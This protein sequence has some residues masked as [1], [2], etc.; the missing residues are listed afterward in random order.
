MFRACA[1]VATSALDAD[2]RTAVVLTDPG[3]APDFAEAAARHPTRVI[4]VSAHRR[5]A[6][7]VAH[8]MALTG[9][10]PVVHATTPFLDRRPHQEL[11]LL[12]RRG[13]AAVVVGPSAPGD[14]ALLDALPG[15]TVQL[16]GHPAEAAGLLAAALRGDGPVYLGLSAPTSP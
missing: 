10:R 1:E 16:P 15:W 11:A 3:P 4:E 14:L 6:I 7:G 5:L 8:G 12:G 9:L 13:S 2:R